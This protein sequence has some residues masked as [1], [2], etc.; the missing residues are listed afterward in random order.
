MIHSPGHGEW[1]RRQYR[2]RLLAFGFATLIFAAA[3]G[4]L[5]LAP[6]NAATDGNVVYVD[7]GETHDVIDALEADGYV[8]IVGSSGDAEATSATVPTL[9][10]VLV[11]LPFVM[12]GAAVIVAAKMSVDLRRI[13]RWQRDHEAFL[14]GYGRESD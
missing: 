10:F 13:K 12:M 2:D 3:A 6:D 14:A 8:V 9:G 4:W 7:E 11:Y 5:A 1:L